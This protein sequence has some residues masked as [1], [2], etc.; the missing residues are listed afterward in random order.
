MI[1]SALEIS[2]LFVGNASNYHVQDVRTTQSDNSLSKKSLHRR[3]HGSL[4]W[5]LNSLSGGSQNCFWPKWRSAL[6]FKAEQLGRLWQ[7]LEN[8]TRGALFMVCVIKKRIDVFCK[9]SRFDNA[10]LFFAVKFNSCCWVKPQMSTISKHWTKIDEKSVE[11][12]S[13]KKDF[14]SIG[15]CLLYSKHLVSESPITFLCYLSPED[16]QSHQNS[17]KRSK[18]L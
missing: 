13:R 17:N 4:L 7:L 1:S 15:S 6:F 12:N 9:C 3:F 14:F 16:L 5:W 2:S 18:S 8:N 11:T 10:L